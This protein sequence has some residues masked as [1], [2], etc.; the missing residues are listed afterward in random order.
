MSKHTVTS[1]LN[2][3]WLCIRKLPV[4][5]C[6]QINTPTLTEIQFERNTQGHALFFFSTSSGIFFFFL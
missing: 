6:I 1:L 5:V 2:Y 4:L 3:E